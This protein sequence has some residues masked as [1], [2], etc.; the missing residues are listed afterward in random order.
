APQQSGTAAGAV[1][2]ARQLGLAL[3]VA[4]L[5]TVFRGAAGDGRPTLPHFVTGL[6]SAVAVASAVG[7]VCGVA[8]FALF[9]TH[10]RDTEPAPAPALI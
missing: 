5:G 6:D 10:E 2:T 9:R 3:G 4:V 8:V 1:N 7:I